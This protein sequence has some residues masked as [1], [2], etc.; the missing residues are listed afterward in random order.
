[1]DDFIASLWQHKDALPSKLWNT[2]F[3]DYEKK[4][5]GECDWL[6]KLAE[7]LRQFGLECKTLGREFIDEADDA[8]VIFIDLFLG[9]RESQSDMDQAIEGISKLLRGREDTPP[10]VILMSR[11]ERLTDKRNVFRDRAGLLGSTFRVV[12]KADLAAPGVLE[13][14]L[15]RLTDHYKDARRVAGF[16]HAWDT[17]LDQARG[18]FVRMLRRLDLSDLAQIQALLLEF[19]GQKLGEYLLDVA[20]GVLQHEIE[21]NAKTIGAALELNKIDLTKYPAPHLVGTSDLQ[22]LV[23]RMVSMHSDRLCLSKDGGKIQLQFGDLLRWKN[24]DGAVFSD[25]V[26]LVIT[27][28]CDLVRRGAKRVALLSGKLENLEP[29]SWSYQSR[30]VRTAI[31]ILPDESRKWIRWNLK[32]VKTLSWDKLDD[33]FNESEGL[34]RIGRLRELYAVEIQQMLLADLGRIGRPANL[35]VS[36]PVDISLFYVGTDSKAQRLEVEEIESA[37]CYVGRDR[38]SNPV[39]RLVLT[40]QACGHI[41]RALRSLADDAVHDSARASLTA[42]RE[43]Q[44]FFTRFERGE[45]EIP[46]DVG[47]E[48]TIQGDNNQVHA[49]IIRAGSFAEGSQATGNKRKAALII[50]VTDVLTNEAN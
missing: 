29:K 45:I 9:F 37:V 7:S 41:E 38:K 32:D 49:V 8:D 30:P 35:P 14:L 19:E 16:I 46:S 42:V 6:N 27:P 40:E 3:E 12:S 50:R 23:Y 15:R 2:L 20:D 13:R 25:D 34:V 4:G 1:M 10:L 21:G 11:S 47:A 44:S 43:E 36:F 33:L 18:N 22:E 28:A 17:G 26:S 5:P 48:K 39:H 31:A 24:E